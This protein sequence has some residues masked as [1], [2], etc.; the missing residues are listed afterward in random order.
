MI[1]AQQEVDLLLGPSHLFRN[2]VISQEPSD[3]PGTQQSPQEPRDILRNLVI[4]QKPSD[5]HRNPVISQEPFLE[6]V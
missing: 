4:T 3:L 6:C 2:P 1:K 5:L